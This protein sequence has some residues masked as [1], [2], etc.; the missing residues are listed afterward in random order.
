MEFQL[1]TWRD[2]EK[3]V[4]CEDLA[5]SCEEQVGF[6]KSLTFIFNICVISIH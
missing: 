2:L 1:L 6:L 4:A 5:V 3:L